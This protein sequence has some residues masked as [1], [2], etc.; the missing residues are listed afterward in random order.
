MIL[1]FNMFKLIVKVI[2]FNNNTNDI[3]LYIQQDN[4]ILW[5]R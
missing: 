5:S 2:L 4:M 3:T 1:L